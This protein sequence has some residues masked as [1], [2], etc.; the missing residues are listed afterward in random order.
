MPGII[1]PSFSIILA[2]AITTHAQNAAMTTTKATVVM[3]T[4]TTKIRKTVETTE[5][6]KGKTKNKINK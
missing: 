4:A 3:T 5:K 2:T 6:I 1:K